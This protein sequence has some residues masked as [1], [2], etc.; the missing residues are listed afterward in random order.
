M[1][2]QTTRQLQ[3]KITQLQQ[4]KEQLRSFLH[5]LIEAFYKSVSQKEPSTW[6]FNSDLETLFKNLANFKTNCSHQP[7]N[8]STS[9]GNNIQPN[10]CGWTQM[11]DL[12]TKMKGKHD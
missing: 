3:A 6:T 8:S 12:F 1:T 5:E 4:E 7:T 11:Q 10:E 9:N 2:K